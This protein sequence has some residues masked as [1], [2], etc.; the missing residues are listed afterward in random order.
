MRVLVRVLAVAGA[1]V[2]ASMSGGTAEAALVTFSDVIDV[3]GC[4]NGVGSCMVTTPIPQQTLAVGDTVDY[5]VTFA[6]QK[7]LRVYD[8]DGGSEWLWAWLFAGDN[9][10]TFT[11]TNASVTL[12]GLDGTLASPLF[13][14]SHTNGMAHIG[15]AYYQDLVATGSSIAFSGYR[16]QY[17]ISA[18]TVSPHAYATNALYV[19]ADRVEVTDAVPE[20]GTLL[21]VGSGLGALTLR[22]RRKA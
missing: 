8:D 1:A 15:P 7:A 18:I 4:P 19:A 6:N 11:I 16:V 20:P 12:L 22:R 5:T 14:A 9:N 17:G 2:A 21:L 13:L 3:S 10:S